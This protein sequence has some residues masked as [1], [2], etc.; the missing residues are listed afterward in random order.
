MKVYSHGVQYGNK[1]VQY[2]KEAEWLKDLEEDLA[3]VERQKDIKI[4]TE[5]MKKQLRMGSTWKA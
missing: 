4:T 5:M 1:S 2:N 3:D